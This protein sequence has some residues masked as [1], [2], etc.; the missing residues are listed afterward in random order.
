MTY[1]IDLNFTIQYV[2]LRI[3]I[4]LCLKTLFLKMIFFLVI[5]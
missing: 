1:Y 4:L 2:Q 5:R 3:W